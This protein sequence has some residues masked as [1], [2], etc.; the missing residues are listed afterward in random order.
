MFEGGCGAGG[1]WWR[2]KKGAIRIISIRLYPPLWSSCAN[3]AVSSRLIRITS[4][5]RALIP[6]VPPINPLPPSP[7]VTLYFTFSPTL[8]GQWIRARTDRI[9]V[10]KLENDFNREREKERVYREQFEGEESLRRLG[11]WPDWT[12]FAF[13]L[14]ERKPKWQSFVP[15]RSWTDLVD[16]LTEFNS[17]KVASHITA[18]ISFILNF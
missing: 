13:Q 8:L 6:I 3:E 14:D 17:I 10:R 5:P 16:S 18:W 12:C 15:I 9:I 4:I 7:S 1:E 2:W 11:L